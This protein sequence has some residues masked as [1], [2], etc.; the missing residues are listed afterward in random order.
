MSLRNAQALKSGILLQD[1]KKKSIIVPIQIIPTQNWDE[2]SKFPEKMN[3]QLFNLLFPKM[4]RCTIFFDR[5]SENKPV[6]L[7]FAYLSSQ[8]TKDL[9]FK[10]KRFVTNLVRFL[11]EVNLKIK[12]LDTQ[13]VL[14]E[15]L[16]KIPKS[17]NEVSPRLFEITSIRKSYLSLT[18]IFYDSEEEK[19]DL[20]VLLRDF[21]SH[22]SYGRVSL[23]I[24]TKTGKKQSDL[25]VEASISITLER[26][27]FDEVK[28]DQRKLQSLLKIFSSHIEDKSIRRYWFVTKAELAENFGKV[29]LGQ[30]WK[31]F[32]VDTNA[33]LDFAAFFSLLQKTS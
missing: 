10:T 6:L 33:L 24:T 23:D 16:E 11:A 8:A 27:N 15:L 1:S 22:L 21:Y 30:G 2:N 17:I 13:E 28:Q 25:I 12:L 31:Y 7:M 4:D 29:I 3:G 26:E 5:D 32:I 18:T 14:K 19:N 9:A 20:V